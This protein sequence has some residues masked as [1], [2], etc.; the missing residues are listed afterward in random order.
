MESK[1]NKENKKQVDK[2]FLNFVKTKKAKLLNEPINYDI[3]ED[4]REN[5]FAQ[6]RINQNVI[7]EINSYQFYFLLKY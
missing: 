1:L 3:D 4:I 7:I 5:P 2:D 6:L